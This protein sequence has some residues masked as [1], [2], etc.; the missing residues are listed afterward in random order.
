MNKRLLLLVCLAAFAGCP[1]VT[2]E[3]E[4]DAGVEPSKYPVLPL[5]RAT[6]VVVG[7][8]YACAL[9]STG[10]VR[11]WGQSSTSATGGT[12]HHFGSASLED[13]IPEPVEVAGLTGVVDITVKYST[14][15]VL[16]NTKKVKCWGR[17][18]TGQVGNG[19]DTLSIDT[20][21][22]LPLS[23]VK[24]VGVGYDHGCAL[25]EDGTVKC[26]GT[27]G[28]NQLEDI[29]VTLQADRWAPLTVPYV[30]GATDLFVSSRATCV[31]I[32]G[33]TRC[34]GAGF[35]YLGATMSSDPPPR[36]LD[37]PNVTGLVLSSFVACGIIGGTAKCW[38]DPN[39]GNL[40]TGAD[41]GDPDVTVPA[42][43]RGL[44][45][46][47]T[48]LTAGCA[49][50]A[51]KAYCWGNFPGLLGNGT[52]AAKSLLPVQV[53]NLTGAVQIENGF[54]TTCA[55][56]SSGSVYCW[57][58]AESGQ[59]GVGSPHESRYLAPQKVKSFE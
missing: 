34:W 50:A 13:N 52:D 1:P 35:P 59:V 27:N 22:E 32:G 56:T 7:V 48:S 19:T 44:P 47:V 2:V 14:V 28:D 11:C 54:S 4:P 21:Y 31:L 58:D 30:T 36:L 20:P 5:A 29:P 33:Q 51:G 9:T 16:T 10:T 26:W 3:P 12:V 23:N 45:T 42:D 37:A 6:K 49:T 15:C 39:N 17:N 38:G 43:V 46:G 55:V 40:G 18:D 24:K 8:G 25:L 53:V 41:F 57:G